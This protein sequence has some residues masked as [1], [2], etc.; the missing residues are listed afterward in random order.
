MNP[1][2]TFLNSLFPA[3]CHSRII[4]VGGTVRDFILA[5]K[6]KDLD[7]VAALTCEELLSLGFHLIEASS[8]ADIYFRHHH[9]FGKVEITLI[10][11]MDSLEDDLRRRD[12]TINAIAMTLDGTI[13]DPLK[14][15]DDLAAKKLRA[16]SSET[17]SNDPLRIFRAFRFECDG[18][19]M[20]PETGDLIRQQDWSAY[21]SSMPI[22]RFGNEMLK[23]LAGT[24]PE[25]FFELMIEFSI[26]AE[27]LPEVFRMPAVPAGPLEHHPEGD[28]LTHSVQV[29]QRVAEITDD[30]L[31]R[32]CAFFHDLG[33]LAT[34]PTLYPK[35]HGHDDA[36]F[37]MAE[38]FCNRLCLPTAYRK[39]LAWVS[40]LHGKVNKW[41]EL[42]DST[43]LKMA[44]QA[45]KAGIVE[46]LTQV[47][48]ADKPG[49]SPITGWDDAVLIAATSASELGVDIEKL[50]TM[51]IDKRPA[52]IMQK[53][54]KVFSGRLERS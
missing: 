12:F 36:G 8:G 53:R 27:F 33:K 22:E 54:I 34:D 40:R 20:T 13:I 23:A 14:G 39:A 46:I 6:C 32:F 10:D 35:H 21:F 19:R 51:P 31:T 41:E 11:S 42:R 25:R 43:K 28:L 3:D 5:M 49:N 52:F 15:C 48:V 16:C 9:D 7:L 18:W 4:M 2:I 47:A 26:G 30:P 45:I 29:L 37:E 24:T 1:E 50:E 38:P 44:E 17:F